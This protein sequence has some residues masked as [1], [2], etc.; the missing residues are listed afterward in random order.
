MIITQEEEQGSTS[1]EGGWRPQKIVSSFPSR[2]SKADAGARVHG[3][4]QPKS[5]FC[6]Q[7]LG[8]SKPKIIGSIC[9]SHKKDSGAFAFSFNQR[10]DLTS[11]CIL[12]IYTLSTL[13]LSKIAQP[14]HFRFRD[15]IGFRSRLLVL[16][17]CN[18][19]C[20]FASC[21]SWLQLA[22]VTSSFWYHWNT[23]GAQSEIK[24]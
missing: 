6:W 15:Q 13:H 17:D 21:A 3:L 23:T 22:Q 10:F 11:C 7:Y 1:K 5:Q 18:Q 4:R 20:A 12:F 8:H 2:H 24:M 19:H 16:G 14:T 9:R